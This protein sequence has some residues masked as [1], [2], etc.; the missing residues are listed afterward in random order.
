MFY[1]LEYCKEKYFG[2]L[3][4]LMCWECADSF[5]FLLEP[6]EFPFGA[7]AENVACPV[8]PTSDCEGKS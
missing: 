1:L 8:T 2:F 6:S 3:L 5:P 4:N 7:K